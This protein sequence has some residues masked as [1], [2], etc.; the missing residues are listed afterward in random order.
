MLVHWL[1]LCESTRKDSL[2]VCTSCS[3]YRKYDVMKEMVIVMPNCLA[4]DIF[5]V[6][7]I[8]SI[9]AVLLLKVGNMVFYYYYVLLI[10]VIHVYWVRTMLD[11]A[12]FF[13]W[14]VL[15]LL[16]D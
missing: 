3:I 9:I 10:K 14:M 16:V 8:T 15:C 13:K 6:K 5:L 1:I 12:K 4:I 11:T 7:T 2:H